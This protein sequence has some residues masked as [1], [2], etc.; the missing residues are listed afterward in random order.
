MARR[1]IAHGA[2]TKILMSS[3]TCR[4]HALHIHVLNLHVHVYSHTSSFI[5]T[6]MQV[7]VHMPSDYQIQQHANTVECVQQHY[8][9]SSQKLGTTIQEY[10][11]NNYTQSTHGGH[12]APSI[13]QELHY[14]SEGSIQ[15]QC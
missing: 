1:P 12:L 7:Q 2:Q 6:H 9:L 15:C 14:G 8:R 13:S 3:G 5:P 10:T 4:P 11:W